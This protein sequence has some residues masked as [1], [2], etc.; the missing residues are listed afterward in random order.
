MKR[1]ERGT[2]HQNLYVNFIRQV[3]FKIY[4]RRRE[5][6]ST[7]YTQKNPQEP[8]YGMAAPPPAMAGTATALFEAVRE[9]DFDRLVQI[10]A[11]VGREAIAPYVELRKRLSS[12]FRG[13]GRFGGGKFV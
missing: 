7:Q 10:Y 9:D 13:T 1:S 2:T 11:N 5:L 12:P 4:E 3:F 6:T 8:S